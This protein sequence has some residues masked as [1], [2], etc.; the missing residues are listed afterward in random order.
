MIRT[1]GEAGT[2]DVVHAVQHMRQ[3]TREMRALTVLSEQE[4][5]AAAKEHQAPYEL[6]R[7]VAQ[8]GKLPVPNFSAGGIATPADAALMMQLGAEAVF[9]GSG[10][11]M[12]GNA[13][14]LDVENN[15]EERAEAVSPRLRHRHGDN[16]F[17]R[18]QDPRRSQRTGHR[19]H[20]GPGRRRHRT[21]RP[22]ANQRLVS[23]CCAANR[24][25]DGRLP[26]APH[27]DLGMREPR[28]LCTRV[29][30]SRF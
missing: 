7:M 28:T 29:P 18:P 22:V 16:A 27:F 25:Q 19:H 17:Q 26:G 3:I 20:E 10:I 8:T 14:P 2:G 9:V 6:I 15:P 12:K 1:K 24:V 30:R 4:L 21:Q 11:F 5:Y 13:T 23:T